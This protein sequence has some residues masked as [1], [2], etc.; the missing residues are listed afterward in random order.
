MK[1]TL[2]I[3]ATFVVAMFATPA[4]AQDMPLL[5]DFTWTVHSTYQPQG[6]GAGTGANF[7][8]SG[9][10]TYT[11]NLEQN[12][13]T[14]S[15][16]TPSNGG[17]FS[18]ISVGTGA[19]LHADDTFSFTTGLEALN[20]PMPGGCGMFPAPARA[21]CRVAEFTTPSNAFA[22][23]SSFTLMGEYGFSCLGPFAPGCNGAVGWQ[24]S[25]D[26]TASLHSA[27][28]SE[29]LTLVVVAAGLL[30]AGALGRRRR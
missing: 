15:F 29:P 10:L 28:A 26:G 20:P 21:S 9:L 30:T 7:S 27:T 23:P 18:F 2:A 16:G 14:M 22:A 8:G 13:V 12:K 11:S 6:G 25:L 3:L 1:S 5:Y 19:G 4:A 17:S 24:S